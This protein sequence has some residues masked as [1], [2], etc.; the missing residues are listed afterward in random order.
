[1]HPARTA[2]SFEQGLRIK[3]WRVSDAV[4]FGFK[5]CASSSLYCAL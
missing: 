4:C 3:L 5:F 1:M 2:Y